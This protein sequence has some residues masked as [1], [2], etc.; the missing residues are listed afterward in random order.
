MLL[1]AKGANVNQRNDN[2]A[3]A[4]EWAL[5][6]QR[7]GR[8]SGAAPRRR[9]GVN[10]GARYGVASAGRRVRRRA[11]AA[12]ARHEL[13]PR[14]SGASRSGANAGTTPTSRRAPSKRFCQ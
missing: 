3:T 8:G 12:P 6:Q 7:A 9:E 13:G 2:G 10:A 14:S 5:Q 1:I 11:G 4:L